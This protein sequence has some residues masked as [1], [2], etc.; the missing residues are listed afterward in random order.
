MLDRPTTPKQRA[1]RTMM[2]RIPKKRQK[3][4]RTLGR[5]VKPGSHQ[6]EIEQIEKPPLLAGPGQGA[7]ALHKG[8]WITKHDE[9]L[10]AAIKLMSSGDISKGSGVSL[11]KN[12]Q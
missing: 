3:K 6:K 5:P 2:A 1:M 11:A 7:G 4:K 9:Y 12:P 10:R 8:Q